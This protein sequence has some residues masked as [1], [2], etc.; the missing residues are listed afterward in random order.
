MRKTQQID[1][2]TGGIY[3]S[4]LNTTNTDF[5]VTI[6]TE[7]SYSHA[8]FSND[9][10]T[11]EYAVDW[12][13]K[14]EER[15]NTISLLTSRCQYNADEYN[16]E[17]YLVEHVF[18]NYDMWPLFFVTSGTTTPTNIRELDPE[19]LSVLFCSLNRVP[20]DHRLTMIDLFAKQDMLNNNDV[21]LV[22]PNDRGGTSYI[23]AGN[24][25]HQFEYWT[26][27][28]RLS[29]PSEEGLIE[30]V[31]NLRTLPVEYWRSL[32]DV[33]NESN[34]YCLFYTEKTA[35]AIWCLK[36]F[37]IFGCKNI[38]TYL[39][40]H[41]FE[42]YDELFDYSFDSIEDKELRYDTGVKELKKLEGRN[43]QELYEMVK[44]KAIRN[45]QNLYK[46]ILNNHVANEKKYANYLEQ[47]V[48]V[49]LQLNNYLKEVQCNTIN[50]IIGFDGDD[51]NNGKER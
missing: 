9:D 32:I 36:P 35:K 34:D 2:W 6:L 15:N 28:R 14:L 4:T 37:L 5:Y 30:D 39:R 22:M 21:T 40:E 27:P 31:T 45:L 26:N 8:E 18:K 48:D 23:L 3:E 50:D 41:G 19:N 13:S 25:P 24:S 7:C 47:P 10:N 17:Q 11:L 16:E 44:P 42:L 1:L 46:L 20:H 49:T 12:K 33:I 43:L 51:V 29:L 38:N